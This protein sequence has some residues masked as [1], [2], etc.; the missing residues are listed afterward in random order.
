MAKR[1]ESRPTDGLSYNSTEAK[2]WDRAGLDK[3]VERVFDICNGCRLCFNLCPSFPT[4]FDAVD[5][6]DERLHGKDAVV[7]DEAKPEG[8]HAADMTKVQVATDHLVG[9]LEA[10]TRWAVV[11]Q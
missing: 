1:I 7:T 11:D 3:E 8:E 2:Y 10:D 6:L 4:L 9:M 5:A